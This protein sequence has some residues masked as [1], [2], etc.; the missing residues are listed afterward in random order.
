MQ[1]SERLSQRTVKIG[2]IAVGLTGLDEIF[3]ALREEGF[4]PDESAAPELLARARRHNYISASAEA[5]YA[6]A[7][8]GEFRAFC[9]REAWGCSCTVDYGTW[10]GQPRETIP[11]Y[12]TIRADL[13]D[14]CGACLRFCSF[15]VYAPG[16]DGKVYVDE[17]FKCQVGC[18]ACVQICKPG[19]IAFPP[20]QVLETFGR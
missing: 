11:W 13:C 2:D 19:A 15:G 1:N 9:Q 17:P 16:D 18:S 5:Q 7:L 6:Q 12:P 20:P 8:L 14:G 10:R 3:A 4:A